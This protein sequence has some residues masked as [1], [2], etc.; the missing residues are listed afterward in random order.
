MGVPHRRRSAGGRPVTPRTPPY[1]RIPHEAPP[2]LVAAA[3]ALSPACSTEP[4]ARPHR[5]PGGRA[6]VAG[7]H[8]RQRD[9]EQPD[10][11]RHL[12]L[13][14]VRQKCHASP[15]D[16]I[17]AEYPTTNIFWPRPCSGRVIRRTGNEFL[18][19]TARH[20]VTQN[21]LL[22]GPLP[23]TGPATGRPHVARARGD[24]KH[25]GV[26]WRDHGRR[27]PAPRWRDGHR[28]RRG[29][30]CP[31]W[32]YRAGPSGHPGVQTFLTSPPGRTAIYWGHSVGG[33]WV[34]PPRPK[35]MA[36]RRKDTA[37]DTTPAGRARFARVSASR[38]PAPT[39]D[40]SRTIKT[41]RS[42]PDNTSGAATP[43]APFTT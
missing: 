34:L 7:A 4:L 10:Q 11:H 41:A 2:H 22:L 8:E 31:R 3:L 13:Q 40:R 12:S 23:F 17:T 37:T 19:L 5:R 14:A 16:T 25:H 28:D 21:G 27:R 15:Q 32:R 9:V 18:I 42:R 33:S 24:Y 39:L 36:G 29:D 26:R 38:S 43:E 20:C 35:G 30:T 1:P 6:R